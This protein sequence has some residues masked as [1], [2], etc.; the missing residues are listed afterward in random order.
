MPNLVALFIS[1]LLSTTAVD[2][3]THCTLKRIS[4]TKEN[5]G[6]LQVS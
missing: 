5:N 1:A 3:G 4:G 2:N 6:N